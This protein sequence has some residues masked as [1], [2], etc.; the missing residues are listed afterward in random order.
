MNAIHVAAGSAS[1]CDI[2]GILFNKDVT[3]LVQYPGAKAAEYIIP[4]TVTKIES[5]S[6]A[7]SRVTKVVIPDGVEEIVY[8]T[9]RECR[10]M[11]SLTIGSGM[12]N[13]GGRAFSYCTG[14]KEITCRSTTPPIQGFLVFEGLSIEDMKTIPL[15]VPA[16]SISAYKDDI[17]WRKFDV[18][19]KTDTAIE[20]VDAMQVN[21]TCKIIRNGRVIIVCGGKEYNVLGVEL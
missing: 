4:S 10:D 8:Y 2:D 5:G 19:D 12:K 6:F 15:Y 7:E 14:L 9:F 20:S 17:N 16:E 18:Q 11:T 3:T 21:S 13:L 1:F